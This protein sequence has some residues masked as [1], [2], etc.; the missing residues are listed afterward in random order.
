M[1]YEIEFEQ[2]PLYLAAR[3]T[4]ENSAENVVRY[5]EDVRGKCESTGCRYVLVHECLE[6]PRLSVLELYKLLSDGVARTRGSFG[7]LALVDESMGDTSEFAETVATNRGMPLRVFHDVE[8]AT[9]WISAE[10]D[11]AKR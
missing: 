5:M 10:A 8:T 7:G 3:V 11:K 4:G 9:Q 2:R 1:S 6:G